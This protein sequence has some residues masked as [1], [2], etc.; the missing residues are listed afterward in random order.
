MS[1]ICLHGTRILVFEGRHQ[2]IPNPTRYF[3][4][5]A[6]DFLSIVVCI[7]RDLPQ[8]KTP[9]SCHNAWYYASSYFIY[10]PIFPWRKG[11]EKLFVLHGASQTCGFS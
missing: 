11:K 7:L 3:S 9:A 5:I 8:G 6:N 4:Y 10:V 2:T 1:N